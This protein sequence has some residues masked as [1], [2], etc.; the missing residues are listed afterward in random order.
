MNR[1]PLTCGPDDGASDE[2]QWEGSKTAGGDNAADETRVNRNQLNE[3]HRSK[4]HY[5]GTQQAHDEQM[6]HFHGHF[7]LSYSQISPKGA[8]IP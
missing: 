8:F 4:N 2:A 6:H 5:H 7:L 1:G 3:P